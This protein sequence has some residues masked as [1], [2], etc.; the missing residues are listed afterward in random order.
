MQSGGDANRQ[1][2]GSRKQSLLAA[3][4]SWLMYAFFQVFTFTTNAIAPSWAA[5][6][7]L[8]GRVLHPHDIWLTDG[9]G[10]I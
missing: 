10:V 7:W 1:F 3:G 2:T 6:P 5:L 8:D 9:Y 4:I